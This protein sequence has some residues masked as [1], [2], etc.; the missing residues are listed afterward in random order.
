MSVH[1]KCCAMKVDSSTWGREQIL[2]FCQK[3]ELSSLP[4]NY[5]YFVTNI[6]HDKNCCQKNQTIRK[7]NRHK[8]LHLLQMCF[9]KL[10]S[11]VLNQ[12]DLLKLIIF[13]FRIKYFLGTRYYFQQIRSKCS[14]SSAPWTR[15]DGKYRWFEKSSRCYCWNGFSTNSFVCARFFSMSFE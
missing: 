15:S 11:G 5:Y 7:R 13:F 10:R 8:W 3:M 12:Y 14:S 4:F 9:M 2:F 6:K 1:K